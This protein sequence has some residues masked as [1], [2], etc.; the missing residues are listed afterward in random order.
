MKDSRTA[1][2]SSFHTEEL[3]EEEDDRT[4]PYPTHTGAM[5]RYVDEEG[6]LIQIESVHLID[7]T[8]NE[9]GLTKVTCWHPELIHLFTRLMM[10]DCFLDYSGRIHNADMDD[11]PNEA[12]ALLFEA[13]HAALR[14]WLDEHYG[15][16]ALIDDLELVYLT[17]QEDVDEHNAWLKAL[18][19]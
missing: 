9:D 16:D 5:R 13:E 4:V 3:P 8:E 15:K 18:V 2:A 14:K 19:F 1:F 6:D 7:V 11:Q 17:V 10:V 12:Q